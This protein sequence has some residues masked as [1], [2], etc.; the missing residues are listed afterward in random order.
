[1]KT[2]NLICQNWSSID[3]SMAPQRWKVPDS[4]V[5]VNHIEVIDH[6]DW[7]HNEL[8]ISMAGDSNHL[9][10]HADLFF[11]SNPILLFFNL[12][13][14]CA[15]MNR[16]LFFTPINMQFENISFFSKVYTEEKFLLF[17]YGKL[18]VNQRCCLIGLLDARMRIHDNID[19]NWTI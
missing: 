5:A 1:M 2:A 6:I 19:P 14:Q 7:L 16:W 12:I 10:P 4:I 18:T 3:N 17:Q 13:Y 11:L 15:E 8:A 9:S